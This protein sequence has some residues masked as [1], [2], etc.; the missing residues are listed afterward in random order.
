MVEGVL[1]THFCDELIIEV[2]YAYPK[3]ITYQINKL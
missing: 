2:L 1:K 3:T